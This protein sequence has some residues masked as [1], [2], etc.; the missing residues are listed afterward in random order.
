MKTNKSFVH[1][2]RKRCRSSGLPLTSEVF[3]SV[4]KEVIDAQ[5]P[6]T[7][8]IRDAK[9]NVLNVVKNGGKFF[10]PNYTMARRNLKRVVAGGPDG[11]SAPGSLRRILMEAFRRG[12]NTKHD[13][14]K[15]AP[16]KEE[17][18]SATT[19]RY[20]NR[21]ELHLHL[22]PSMLSVENGDIT[23]IRR[24]LGML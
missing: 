3:K 15:R 16:S 9:Q 5:D 17:P 7:A 8:S 2:R 14:K 21:Y 20:G 24:M 22:D 19:D 10:R 6:E 23:K 4:M 12:Q 11:T 13:Q 1:R 18:A